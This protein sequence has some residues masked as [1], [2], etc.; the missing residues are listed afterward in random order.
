MHCDGREILLSESS[1]P[2]DFSALKWATWSNSLSLFCQMETLKTGTHL[3]AFTVCLKHQRGMA[4]RNKHCSYYGIHEGFI[5][6]QTDALSWLF[7]SLVPLLPSAFKQKR[8]REKTDGVKEE[9]SDNFKNPAVAMTTA[10]CL[11]Q[12][13][14]LCLYYGKTCEN[15]EW[16]KAVSAAKTNEQ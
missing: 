4:K 12:V 11:L 5:Y 13:R 1:A 2:E 3:F 16:H 14:P 15:H 7:A 9:P 10:G 8:R 6:F